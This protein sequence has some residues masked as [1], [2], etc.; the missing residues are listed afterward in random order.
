[1]RIRSRCREAIADLSG[2]YP[3]GWHG[4]CIMQ[5]LFVYVVATLLYLALSATCFYAA[6]SPAIGS[7]IAQATNSRTAAAINDARILAIIVDIA[8]DFVR[9]SAYCF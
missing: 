9:T 6:F 5:L 8:G 3:A 4:H 2:R 7:A 1:M